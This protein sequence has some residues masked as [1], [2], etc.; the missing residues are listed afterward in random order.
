MSIVSSPK[1][2]SGKRVAMKRP[3]ISEGLN[4]L[5]YFM[6]HNKQNSCNIVVHSSLCDHFAV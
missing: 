6:C 5:K 4:I 1:N 2:E 3:R